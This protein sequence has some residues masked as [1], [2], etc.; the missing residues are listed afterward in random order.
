[1][2]FTQHFQIWNCFTIRLLCFCCEG[3]KKTLKVQKILKFEE[4]CGELSV[5]F[6][7]ERH[8]SVAKIKKSSKVR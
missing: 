8:S 7:F 6:F 2:M 5:E 3:L 1:M 4:D